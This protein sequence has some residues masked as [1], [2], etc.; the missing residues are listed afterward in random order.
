MTNALHSYPELQICLMMKLHR[1]IVK[2]ICH[3]VSQMIL[4]LGPPFTVCTCSDLYTYA[5][6][7][8]RG[9]D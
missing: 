9:V 7:I 5:A 6:L 2:R 1:M 3:F 4:Y 8:I